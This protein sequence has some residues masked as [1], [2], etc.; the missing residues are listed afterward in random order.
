M[1]RPAGDKYEHAEIVHSLYR[2]S[3][4]TNLRVSKMLDHFGIERAS[5]DEK[6]APQ[7]I[8][9]WGQRP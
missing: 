6:T 3:V 7:V 1:A 2:S 5:E 8:G 9:D 4:R